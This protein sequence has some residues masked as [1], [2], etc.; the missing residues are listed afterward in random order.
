MSYKYSF[1]DNAVY[2]ADDVNKITKRL[3]TA[4]IEDS[5]ENGVA[6]NVSKFNEVGKQ[7]YTSGVVPESCQTLK[8]TS[9]G[10][11]KILINPGLAFFDDGSVI[12]IEAGG[13]EL[14]YTKDMVN[15][16]YLK[17]DLE[18]ANISFP[19]CATEEPEGDFVLLAI[20][21]EKGNIT[22][23]RKYAQGKLPGYQSL[24]LGALYINENVELE[25]TNNHLAE[26]I[27]EFDV[28]SN[29]FKHIFSVGKSDLYGQYETMTVYNVED[30]SIISFVRKNA[31]ECFFDMDEM[32]F[33]FDRD[34]RRIIS[35][36]PSLAD[37]KLRLNLNLVDFRN[38]L[39]EVGEKITVNLQLILV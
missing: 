6:Y 29:N 3:V 4:G 18:S 25:I 30:G 28:G 14:A 9:F 17:N 15:Y 13:E 38:D 5:F 12:E 7:V 2:S 37:G 23:K 21:D 27:A 11:G 35:R 8:V 31:E 26:G 39:V 20:I 10:E 32:Y 24:A 34:R 22:D 36:Q 16:V 1:A 33:Y 19:F